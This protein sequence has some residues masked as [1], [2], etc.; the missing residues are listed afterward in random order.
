[1]ARSRRAPPVR[2]LLSTRCA[3]SNRW[4]ASRVRNLPVSLAGH[5]GPFKRLR[6]LDEK[7]T[8]VQRFVRDAHFDRRGRRLYSFRPHSPEIAIGTPSSAVDRFSSASTQSCLPDCQYPRPEHPHA[9][10]RTTTLAR[11]RPDRRFRTLP[12]CTA[13]HLVEPCGRVVD[14][15]AACRHRISTDELVNAGACGFG[16]RLRRRTADR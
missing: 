13:P 7:F 16:S 4:R 3:S 6:L 1:M 10:K 14:Q 5:A 12:V 8:L 2:R 11:S 9:P 15:H